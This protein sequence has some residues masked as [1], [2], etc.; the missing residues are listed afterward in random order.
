M[1]ECQ[2]FLIKNNFKKKSFFSCNFAE[3][4]PEN[5]NRNEEKINKRKNQKKR[6]NRILKK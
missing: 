6:I 1:L 5:I 4:F 2:K 3:S